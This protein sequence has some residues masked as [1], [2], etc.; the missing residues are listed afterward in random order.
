[1]VVAAPIRRPVLG[2]AGRAASRGRAI[3]QEAL[4][5]AGDQVVLGPRSRLPKVGVFSPFTP[6]WL[7]VEGERMLAVEKRDELLSADGVP[8][9]RFLVRRAGGAAPMWGATPRAH[10]VGAPV[11]LAHVPGIY[12]HTK[13]IVVD[14]VFVGIGSC[15]TNRRGFFHDGEIQAF[16]VPEQL[17][18]SRENPALALRTSLWAE[19]LG[20]PPAMGRALLADPVA[21]VELFRRSTYLG[22]RLS[23]FDALGAR[24]DLAFLGEKVVWAETLASL[25]LAVADD[26]VPYVWNTFIEPTSLSEPEPRVPGPGL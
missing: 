22:N 26:V 12:V 18:A 21:A 6:F 5:V 3:L 24:T 16:A 25:G 15:N 19:H 2:D 11:T 23:S 20:L 8:S 1:M 14:D 4:S 7:W 17:K 9:R 10:E 13:V